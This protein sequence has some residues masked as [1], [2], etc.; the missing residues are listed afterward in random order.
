MF[1]KATG[2]KENV[3]MKNERQSSPFNGSFSQVSSSVNSASFQV[4][5]VKEF[6]NVSDLGSSGISRAYAGALIVRRVSVVLRPCFVYVTRVVLVSARLLF[7]SRRFLRRFP[8]V[9]AVLALSERVSGLVE[10]DAVPALSERSSGLAE[11]DSS[12]TL[13]EID[14]AGTGDVRRVIDSRTVCGVARAAAATAGESE[15]TIAMLEISESGSALENSTAGVSKGTIAMLEISESGSALV[16]STSGV[17]A[18]DS[19]RIIGSCV[20]QIPSLSS[21]GC[22][23][24]H[25]CASLSSAPASAASSCV[26]PVTSSAALSAAVAH[27]C[28][29]PIHNSCPDTVSNSLLVER[30]RKVRWRSTVGNRSVVQTVDMSPAPAA[31]TYRRS[32]DKVH[33]QRQISRKRQAESS[34]RRSRSWSWCWSGW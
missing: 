10:T 14:A 23:S 17:T 9:D 1:S 24:V 12:P 18:G 22:L 15:G 29:T 8:L 3:F 5:V 19:E 6:F 13:S 2:P 34:G 25:A 11:T 30:C 20:S 27:A 21:S 26:C 28:S 31:G 4:P 32:A 7:L 16:S 33:D